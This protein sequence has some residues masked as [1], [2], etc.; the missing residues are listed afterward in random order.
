L[1]LIADLWIDS[2]IHKTAPVPVYP[3]IDNLPYTIY[4]DIY[5]NILPRTHI[6]EII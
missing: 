6:S 1:V 5:Y 3:N 4:M 2:L